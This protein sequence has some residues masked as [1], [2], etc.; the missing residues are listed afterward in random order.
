M[1]NRIISLAGFKDKPYDYGKTSDTLKNLSDTFTA[2]SG[3]NYIL[4][5]L[6]IDTMACNSLS[7]NTDQKLRCT[8]HLVFLDIS[9]AWDSLDHGLNFCRLFLENVHVGTKN[10]YGQLR[11]RAG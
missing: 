10:F 6:H 7:I 9:R 2:D 4:N 5:I 11:L 8:S 1:P 3:S